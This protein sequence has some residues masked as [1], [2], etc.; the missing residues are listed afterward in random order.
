MYLIKDFWFNVE[1]FL[2]QENRGKN[3]RT[4]TLELKK[5]VKLLSM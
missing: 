3:R 2:K 4:V 1:N 5:I